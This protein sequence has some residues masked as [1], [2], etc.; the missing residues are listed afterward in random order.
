VNYAANASN[1]DRFAVAA[2]SAEGITDQLQSGDVDS[3]GINGL[4]V[5]ESDQ[6]PAGVWVA[7]S[8]PPRQPSGRT[9]CRAT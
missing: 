4:A 6:S 1:D 8:R 3:V 9:S 2:T 5:P 7:S